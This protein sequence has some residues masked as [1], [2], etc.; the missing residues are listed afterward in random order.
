MQSDRITICEC[1]EFTI[2]LEYTQEAVI[3]HTKVAENFNRQSYRKMKAF[4]EQ[5]ESFLSMHY[6]CL[7]TAMDPA[8]KDLARLAQHGGFKFHSHAEGLDIY[9]KLWKGE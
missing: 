6:P 8:R 7:W 9:Q 3:W 5:L 4:S 1:P 2:E